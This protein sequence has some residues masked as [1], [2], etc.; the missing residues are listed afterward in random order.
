VLERTPGHPLAVPVAVRAK[1][2]LSDVEGAER[3]AARALEI[4]PEDPDLIAARAEVQIA[5]HD[6]TG[7]L[8]SLRD[9]IER[10]D[11]DAEL[12]V[13]RGETARRLGEIAEARAA[14][15]AAL[16]HAP[17]NEPALLG[18]LE[19]ANEDGDPERGRTALDAI[20][21]ANLRGDRVDFAEAK[22]LVVSGAG[23]RGFLTVRRALA[24]HPRD[25]MLQTTLGDLFL[26]AEEYRAAANAFSAVRD[27]TENPAEA[28]LGRTM[29][30]IRLGVLGQVSEGLA[31]ART[32]AEARSLGPHFEALVLAAEARVLLMGD[33][34][35]GAEAKANAAVALDARCGE[36]HLVLADI[37]SAR[38]QNAL[39]ELR[40]AASGRIVSVEAMGRVYLSDQDSA[41]ACDMARGYLHAAPA[42]RFAERIRDLSRRC[43]R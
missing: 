34:L 19:L 22:F 42:G 11:D 38:N 26:Q 28:L 41:N 17:T 36:A 23:Q 10:R 13:L 39:P 2:A 15:D 3:I 25:I 35:S 29:S 1:L 40:L 16:S 37:A 8:A 24:R 30:Q 27:L 33:A 6:D 43:G 7:A 32:A 4:H 5:R 12:H 21:E 14:F 20:H 18:A 9:A 31:A